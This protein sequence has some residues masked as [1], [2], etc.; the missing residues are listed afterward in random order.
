[1]AG[2]VVPY[3]GSHG[4]SRLAAMG[5]GRERI[6]LAM[7]ADVVTACLA[8]GE[9]TL[10]TSGEEA[11]SLAAELGASVVTDPG[12]G[13]GA[14]VEA[15]LAAGEER[16]ALVV[17]AD[18]PAATPR[19]LLS[20]LGAMPPQGMAIVE[21]RDGT[22]N[23]LALSAPHLFSPLYGPGSA[24]RFR[25]H[26]ARLGIELVVADIPNLVADVDLPRDLARLDGSLGAHT[27]AILS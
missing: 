8:V 20:L 10:V 6:A 4:K 7:L 2:L 9:T 18:L 26:A 13:Q 22:T 25:E 12:G 5:T 27:Q 15:A 1:M 11:T 24:E 23:A 17:N 16:P 14:A 21:A 19:D 3:P